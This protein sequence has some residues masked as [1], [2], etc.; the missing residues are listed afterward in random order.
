[1]TFCS[2]YTPEIDES[3]NGVGEGILGCKTDRDTDHPQSG[4]GG[5]HVDPQLRKS[6]DQSE[7]DQS[8]LVDAVNQQANQ[9]AVKTCA[10]KR[11]LQG[12]P[13]RSNGQL[14]LKKRVTP[15]NS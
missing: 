3:G 13:G 1:M 4:D 12:P 10:G 8:I 15:A 6:H 14:R 7:S 9:L 5:A 2:T 11:G